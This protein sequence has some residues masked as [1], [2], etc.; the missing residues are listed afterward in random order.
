M[1]VKFKKGAT[2]YR[3]PVEAV[4]DI[5]AQIGFQEPSVTVLFVS[6]F[7]ELES[8]SRQIRMQFRGPVICYTTA[9]EITSVGYKNDR[10]I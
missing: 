6:S 4:D 7:Y 9:G 1:E 2:E 5:V 10:N 8:L 3:D